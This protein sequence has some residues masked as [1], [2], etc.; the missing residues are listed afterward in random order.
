MYNTK[1]DHRE[2]LFYLFLLFLKLFYFSKNFLKSGNFSKN[3]N[4]FKL[5][6]NNYRDLKGSTCDTRYGNR[7]IHCLS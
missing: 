6:K 1:N 3:L 4:S 2:L 5:S 7:N